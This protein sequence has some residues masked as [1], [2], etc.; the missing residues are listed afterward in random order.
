MVVVRGVKCTP[1]I[2]GDATYLIQLYLQKRIGKHV[3]ELMWISRD[4]III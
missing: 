4:I 2:I 1:Y 3:M